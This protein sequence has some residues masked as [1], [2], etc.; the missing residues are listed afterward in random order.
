MYRRRW[1]RTLQSKT[2]NWDQEEKED[3]KSL[4]V[5]REDCQ[6]FSLLGKKAEKLAEAF[7]YPIRFVP[8]NSRINIYGNQK[9]RSSMTLTPPRLL[10]ELI[11]SATIWFTAFKKLYHQYL[12][13]IMVVL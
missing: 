3:F 5:L 10:F 8:R 11:I 13:K 7:K 1:K 6:A 2:K 4:S 9:T 12:F